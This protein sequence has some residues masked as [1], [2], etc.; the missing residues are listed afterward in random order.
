MNTSLAV[1]FSFLSFLATTPAAVVISE[2]L[3]NPPGTDSTTQTI[4]LSGNPNEAYSG[5]LSTIEMDTGSI[6]IIDRQTMISGTLNAGG[7]ATEDIPDLENPSFTLL[8]HSANGGGSNTDLD[9]G[10]DGTLD[11]IV[12]LGIIFDAISVPD[13]SADVST[14][15]V[16]LGGQDFT[17]GASATGVAFRDGD[18]G[19]WLSSNESGS[20]VRA[21]NGDDAGFVGD[22]TAPTFG[23]ANPTIPEPSASALGLLGILIAFGRRR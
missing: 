18:T 23:S 1:F 13:T 8:F 3:P 17:F 12:S 11:S 16:Q 19:A 21:I 4:E 14:Y 10:D 22:F 9:P 7:F 15:G 20:G 6:G 2:F 5:F